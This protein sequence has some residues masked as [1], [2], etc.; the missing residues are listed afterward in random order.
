MT[1]VPAEF[2]GPTYTPEDIE[3]LCRIGRLNPADPARFLQDL[4]DS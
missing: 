1:I 2:Y 3:R 4:E